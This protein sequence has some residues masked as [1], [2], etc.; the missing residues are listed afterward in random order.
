MVPVNHMEL[1]VGGSEQANSSRFMGLNTQTEP[2]PGPR[3]QEKHPE[4]S[5]LTTCLFRK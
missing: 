2:V 3:L 5:L 1:P 4:P